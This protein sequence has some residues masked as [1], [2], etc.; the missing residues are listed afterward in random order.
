MSAAVSC[1]KVPCSQIWHIRAWPSSSGNG[2]ARTIE[3]NLEPSA[4]H[5][6]FDEQRTGQATDVVPALVDDLLRITS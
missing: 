1:S 2:R 3:L 6:Q 4:V 5:G